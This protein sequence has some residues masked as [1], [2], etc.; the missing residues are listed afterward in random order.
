MVPADELAW[1]ATAIQDG[2]A[3]KRRN[4]QGLLANDARDDGLTARNPQDL[5][6]ERGHDERLQERKSKLS[7]MSD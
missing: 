7:G 5:G 3:A 4:L 1:S 6:I 2:S